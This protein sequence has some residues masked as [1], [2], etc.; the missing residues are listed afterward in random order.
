MPPA[1]PPMGVPSRRAFLQA[2]GAAVVAG[3]ALDPVDVAP[4]PHG[5]GPEEDTE[6]TAITFIHGIPGKEDELQEHLLSLSGPTRAEPGC[7]RYDLFRSPE[8]RHEFVRLEVWSSLEALEAH[9]RMPHLRAS[10]ERRQ[11]EGWTTRIMVWKR[12]P[13]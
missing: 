4:P 11:R 6:I 10:F 7:R 5:L 1:T 12:V 13:G 8:Q 9:K 3:I 2:G